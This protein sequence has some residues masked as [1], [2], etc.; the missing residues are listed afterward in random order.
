M[1][2]DI[3]KDFKA[4]LY[5]RVASP[6]FLTFVGSWLIWNFRIVLVVTSSSE[7][8]AKLLRISSLVPIEMLD[9][10][11]H[12]AIG[13][14][15]TATAFLLLYPFPAKWIYKYWH[16]R[17]KELKEIK[18]KIED[19]TPL[20]NE[21]SRAIK[22]QMREL[23]FR[24]ETDLDQRNLLVGTLKQKIESYSNVE[25]ERVAASLA[26]KKLQDATTAIADLR[27]EIVALREKQAE[28]EA[29][30]LSLDKTGL[31]NFLDK[32]E[33][34]LLKAIVDK[35]NMSQNFVDD[36]LRYLSMKRTEAKLALEELEEKKLVVNRGVDDEGHVIYE[37]TK[38]GRRAALGLTS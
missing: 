4:S 23:Q 21:A 6:L 20:T 34:R 36:Q 35:E 37:L 33:M 26:E 28:R 8:D 9:K 16:E 7:I 22:S 10:L 24:Y 30:T 32:N 11:W 19:D 13:P 1:I 2:D 14:L 25:D 29:S 17:Q 5:E 18:Q 38:S 31:A 3:V 15:F 27:A 12:F